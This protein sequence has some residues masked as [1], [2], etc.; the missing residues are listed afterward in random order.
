MKVDMTK[1]KWKEAEEIGPMSD[2]LREA[3]RQG[4]FKL[5]LSEKQ[6][7]RAAAGQT[8]GG[9]CAVDTAGDAIKWEALSDNVL[10]GEGKTE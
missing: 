8:R 4:N 1:E 6:L 10:S 5:K 3:A 7:L 2:A 9:I